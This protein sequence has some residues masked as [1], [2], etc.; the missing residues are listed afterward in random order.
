MSR[1][2][3]AGLLMV[4]GCVYVL[5]LP[6][7]DGASLLATP[8]TPKSKSIFPW[9]RPAPRS[10]VLPIGAEK[11][12][13]NG[14]VCPADGQTQV[15]CDLPPSLRMH[16]TGGMGVRGPGTGAGLC[17]FTSI[18]HSGRYQNEPRLFGFQQKMTKEIGGGYPDK[19]DA[20][21]LKY[22]PGV[23][24]V[25][26]T[27]GDDS[28]L[29]SALKTGRMVCV[30]YGGNDDFYRGAIA[31]MVN[32]IYLDEKNACILDNNR[33]TVYVWMSADEFLKRWRAMNGGWAIVLNNP[34]PPPPPK[35]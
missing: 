20:M 5:A 31:H 6:R 26:H 22:A 23:E 24:Y 16:N 32:L 1:N 10:P 19:V 3:I 8:A 7:P 17:V 14:P 13:P 30:T 25:Q 29:K 2:G 15:T 21:I 28:F 4:L 35:N 33:E 27:R 11:F 12:I 18:E 9:K 34:A